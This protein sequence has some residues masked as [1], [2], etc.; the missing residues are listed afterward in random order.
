MVFAFWKK[1]GKASFFSLLFQVTEAVPTHGSKED[2]VCATHQNSKHLF[3][4]SYDVFSIQ[5]IPK[6]ADVRV[7]APASLVTH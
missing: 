5:L 7:T 2:L 6:P 4:Q 1:S 3:Y